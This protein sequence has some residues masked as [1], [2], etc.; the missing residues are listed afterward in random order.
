MLRLRP[1]KK[2]L[3]ERLESCTSKVVTLRDLSNLA[4]KSKK[5]NPRN[6]LQAAVKMLQDNYKATVRLL[7][8]ENNELRALFL[9]DEAM[10]KSFGDYPEIIFI[11]ATYKLLETRMSCFLV[12]VEDG[13]G[14]SEIVAAGLFATEDGDTLRW[15]FDVF[16]ELN[17]SWDAIRIVMAD[18]DWK[19]RKVVTELLPQASLHICAFHTLQT[20][21]RE[22]SVR[23]LGIS[24]PEQEMALDLLQRMVYAQNEDEYLQL[25]EVF[26]SSAPKQVLD[27]FDLNWHNIRHEWVMGLKWS[28]SNFFNSTNNRAES[29][30]AKLKDIVMRYSSLENFVTDF[31]CFV[32]TTRKERSHKGATLLQKKRIL[33]TTDEDYSRYCNLLTPYAFQHV[34]RQLDRSADMTVD[35]SNGALLTGACTCAFRV[36]M[37][38]PCCHVLAARR[39]LGLSKFDGSLCAPR[40]LLEH[41]MES[42]E[43]LL[44]QESRQPEAVRVDRREQPPCQATKNSARPRFSQGELLGSSRK[45]RQQSFTTEWQCLKPFCSTG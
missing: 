20:F 26:K 5:D 8:D 31:F 1:D 38:L 36:A 7:S 15:F 24:K 41:Y 9:Q 33:K 13:N 12:I 18:K 27:Y 29:M 37:L 28:C 17:P 23:K 19:E 11:D 44:L 14:E 25:Y 3:R 42:R 6:N 34:K 21:R 2:L 22:V 45:C 32:H 30:N 4:A 16:K 39:Q 40:W 35:T 43:E 10:K